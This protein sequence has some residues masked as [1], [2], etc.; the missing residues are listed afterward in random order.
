MGG[1]GG[2]GGFSRYIGPGTGEQRRCLRG[3]E[4]PIALAIDVLFRFFFGIFNYVLV[5]LEK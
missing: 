1:G 2:G 4:W 5:Y 3:F